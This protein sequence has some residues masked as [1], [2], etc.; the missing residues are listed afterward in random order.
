MRRNH[1]SPPATGPR[2]K[3]APF[4]HRLRPGFAPGRRLTAVGVLLAAVLSLAAGCSLGYTALHPGENSGLYHHLFEDVINTFDQPY[5]LWVR[6]SIRGDM[7]G[8]GVV[9]EEI[10]IATIQK[11][12]EKHPGPIELALLVVCEVQL[13]GTRK[14][15]AR[16]RLFEGDPILAAP[17]PINDLGQAAPRPLTRVRAQ[18]LQDKATLMEFVVVYFWADPAPSPVWFAGYRLDGERLVKNLEVAMHQ[19]HPGFVTVNLDPSMEA[20]P[21]GYQLAFSVTAVPERIL[22]KLDSPRDPP[23]WGHAYARNDDG[24]YEQA[25]WRFGEQYRKIENAWNQLYLKA[26]L[27]K[28]PRDELAWLEYHM[29]LLNEYAGDSHLA[30]LLLERAAE[31]AKDEDLVEAVGKA[32]EFV[33]GREKP[34]PPQR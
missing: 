24:Y 31:G 34:W 4:P 2:T 1:G 19:P 9:E 23:M 25:D 17:R 8:N 14:A 22:K 29:G 21:Y 20:T 18:M 16:T 30:R 6:G 26:L 12:T 7:N 5:W 27:L 33:R 10:V 3:T 13:D 32:L 11:G 28:L 15:I